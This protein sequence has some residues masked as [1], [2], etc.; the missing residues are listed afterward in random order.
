MPGEKG[1]KPHRCDWTLEDV[2]VEF[3]VGETI[4][5]RPLD[6]RDP[7]LGNVQRLSRRERG[8]VL[9]M[10]S[11]WR[12]RRLRIGGLLC[13]LQPGNTVQVLAAVFVLL[14]VRLRWHPQTWR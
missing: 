5:W 6:D 11:P 12:R 7:Q 4:C 8:P 3:D 10:L 13:G 9:L 14:E 2:F 1:R